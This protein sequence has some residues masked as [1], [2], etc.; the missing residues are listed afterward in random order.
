MPAGMCR[1][2][3]RRRSVPIGVG[4]NRHFLGFHRHRGVAFRLRWTFTVVPYLTSTRKI[5]FFGR[6][7]V[8]N[9]D[10]II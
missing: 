4:F 5:I 3:S 9:L 7:E 2:A 1:R 10:I 8:K 6:V